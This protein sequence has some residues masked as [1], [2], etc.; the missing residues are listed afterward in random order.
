MKMKART[1]VGRGEKSLLCDP[2]SELRLG[3]G[4]KRR[5][6]TINGMEKKKEI[7]TRGLSEQQAVKNASACFVVW[8]AVLFAEGCCFRPWPI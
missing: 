7:L 1:V 2:G 8:P 3:G 6:K 4:E 5:A